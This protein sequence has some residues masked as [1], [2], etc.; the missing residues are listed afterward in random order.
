MSRQADY[1]RRNRAAGLCAKCPNPSGGAYYCGYHRHKMRLKYF[2]RK[3]RK[4]EGK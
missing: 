3:A 1:S 2:R 4:L